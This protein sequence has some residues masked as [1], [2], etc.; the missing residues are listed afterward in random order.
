MGLATARFPGTVLQWAECMARYTGI[1]RDA[2]AGMIA[3]ALTAHATIV[4]DGINYGTQ[5]A[6]GTHNLTPDDW[7]KY[8][9]LIRSTVLSDSEASTSDPRRLCK[10]DREVLAK[11]CRARANPTGYSAA[12]PPALG[13][14]PRPAGPQEPPAGST[15]HRRPAGPS[16]H[17]EAHALSHADETAT[18]HGRTGTLPLSQLIPQAAAIVEF[19]TTAEPQLAAHPQPIT[20]T[21]GTR[22]TSHTAS[23]STPKDAGADHAATHTSVS[24]VGPPSTAPH[25]TAYPP[26]RA[27]ACP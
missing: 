15:G 17:H 13:R 11:I 23:I 24:L 27:T 25:T 22:V 8:D 14:E 20:L 10:L 16:G 7:L 21:R 4:L 9:A 12:A 2:S 3:D 6:D 26:T 1:V 18:H 19:V 5:S